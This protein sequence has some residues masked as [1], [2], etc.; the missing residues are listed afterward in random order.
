[1]CVARDCGMVLSYEQVIQITVKGDSDFT[2][3]DWEVVG[4][5]QTSYRG[6]ASSDSVS[7]NFLNTYY[8][9]KK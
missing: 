8:K 2:K 3:I 4:V 6:S 5:P 7:L 9:K 1:M